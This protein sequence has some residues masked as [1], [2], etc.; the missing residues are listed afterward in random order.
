MKGKAIRIVERNDRSFSF[1]QLEKYRSMSNILGDIRRILETNTSASKDNKTQI[2][3]VCSPISHELQMLFSMCMC[4]EMS[5][6]RKVIYLNLKECSGFYQVFGDI[7]SRDLEDLM[8]VIQ[9]P[10]VTL[11]EYD[12]FAEWYNESKRNGYIKDD[13]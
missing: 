5:I 13:A 4:K 8:T 10:E 3:V 11:E 6:N 12:S 1:P 7:Q 2:T 9:K